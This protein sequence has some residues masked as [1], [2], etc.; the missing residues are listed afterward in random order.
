MIYINDNLRILNT[1]NRVWVE[2][3]IVLLQ[4]HL[5]PKKKEGWSF[6]WAKVFKDHSSSIYAL[7]EDKSD[8][9]H[10]LIQLISDDGMLIMELIEL[11]PFNIGTNKEFENVAGCLIAFGCRESLKLKTDYKGF[12]TFVSKT[13]LVQLYKTKYLATQ[14]LGTRMYIDPNSGEKLINKYLVDAKR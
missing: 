6:N 3:E 10:G 11:A 13:S 5:V 12:L 4:K 1:K 7:I 2:C 8:K 14:T 9:I